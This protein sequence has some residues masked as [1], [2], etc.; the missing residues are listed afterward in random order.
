M[1][2][3]KAV[4]VIGAGNIGSAVANIAVKAGATT[5]V[6][7]RDAAKA[8]AVSDKVIAGTVSETA[9]TGDIVV[10][11]LPYPAMHDVLEANKAQLAGKIV[12]DVTN[13]IDFSTGDMLE[14]AE[15]SAAEQF[16]SQFPEVTILK[17]F[18]TNFAATLATG[19]IAG[20]PTTIMVAGDD[21]EAKS[22]L[23]T[24]VDAA[25]YKSVDAGA[26]KR[27]RNMEAFGALQINLAVAEQISWM[28]GFAVEAE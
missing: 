22:S 25:G 6:L 10:I 17:A 14:I 18:N 7:D 15:G 2:E 13:P 8:K 1:A 11:A 5:Q 3:V 27:A 23:R 21:D 16:A 19:E 26:L 4:T 24:L 9:I 12:V 28:G 20:K